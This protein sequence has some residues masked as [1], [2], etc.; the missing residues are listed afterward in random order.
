MTTGAPVIFG[1]DGSAAAQRAVRAAAPLLGRQ[2]A[3]VVTV[4]EAGR[5]FDTSTLPVIGLEMPPTI[6]DLRTA[7]EVDKELCETAERT[8][9]AGANIARDAGFLDA[10]GLAV[11]DDA[12]VAET[13]MRVARERHS[14]GIVVGA[15]GHRKLSEL[16]L[17]STSDTLVHKADR[18]VVVVRA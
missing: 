14:P 13:L 16:L 2:P 17:G 15:H 12:D 11:A 4:W 7:A 5:R 6:L 3:L 1:F 8:A 10:T 9:A 18:P